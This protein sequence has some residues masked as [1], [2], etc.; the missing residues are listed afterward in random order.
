MVRNFCRPKSRQDAFCAVMTLR[1]DEV[2]LAN[3]CMTW[4]PNCQG[5]IGTWRLFQFGVIPESVFLFTA[6][7]FLHWVDYQILT[8]FSSVSNSNQTERRKCHDK[9]MPLLHVDLTFLC[10][11]GEWV[12]WS[13]PTSH[14]SKAARHL[15]GAP[16]AT[17][18]L[19]PSSGT[20][21]RTITDSS[22]AHAAT[23]GTFRANT[24]SLLGT[25]KSRMCKILK[26]LVSCLW[27][28]MSGFLSSLHDK[29]TGKQT[30]NLENEHL[31]CSP[32]QWLPGYLGWDT[33][34]SMN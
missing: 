8:D 12:L 25:K 1:F 11:P 34:L 28:F 33:G 3:S 30:L 13:S 29:R 26:T 2:F 24:F 10:S 15:S 7:T 4:D 31:F 21:V 20:T 22:R 18:H 9:V 23:H 5:S 17:R 14:W 16:S 6:G 27:K 32:F 19:W